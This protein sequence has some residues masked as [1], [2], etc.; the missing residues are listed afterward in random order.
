RRAL[1]E[2]LR[3]VLDAGVPL[4]GASDHGVSEAIYLDDPDRN[5]VELYRDRPRE[6]WPRGPDGEGVAMFNAPFDLAELLSE[7]AS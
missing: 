5:G 2:A 7:L 3:R 4:T 6:E 1:A